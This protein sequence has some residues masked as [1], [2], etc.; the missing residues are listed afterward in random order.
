MNHIHMIHNW[1]YSHKQYYMN[2]LYHVLSA[3]H[4]MTTIWRLY[5]N[6]WY[7]ISIMLP[8]SC[9]ICVDG[10]LHKQ[11]NCRVNSVL[12]LLLVLLCLSFFF[13]FP[14]SFFFLSSL[15]HL[16][17]YCLPHSP[18]MWWKGLGTHWPCLARLWEI[19][20]SYRKVSVG[21]CSSET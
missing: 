17:H 6:E 3:R 16:I 7:F 21:I 10:R 13:S 9:C 20:P 8:Q 5:N 2:G 14:S 15:H 18:L 19:K 12:V 4:I 11:C 1:S